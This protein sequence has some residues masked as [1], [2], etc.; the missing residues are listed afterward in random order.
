LYFHSPV[1]LAHGFDSGNKAI[2]ITGHYD[3]HTMTVTSADMS[4]QSP[5]L[6]P[7]SL[8]RM[9]DDGPVLVPLRLETVRIAYLQLGDRVTAALHTQIGDRLHL[10]EQHSGVL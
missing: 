4:Q 9:A 5:I 1:L 8:Y 2:L 3:S 10:P 6:L 7:Q